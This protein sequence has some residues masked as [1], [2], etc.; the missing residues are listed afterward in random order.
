MSNPTSETTDSL[1]ERLGAADGIA[2]LVDDIVAAH[3]SNPI[4]K[5]RFLPYQEDPARLSAIKSH[6]R[7]FLAMG[8]GGPASYAGRSM[9]DAHRGMNVSAA[10]Y[11]AAVD[12]ILATLK[13]HGRDERTQ[14][15][16]LAI[17]YSLKAE[18]MSL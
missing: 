1:Y 7:A 18:I 10:E 12:D 9:S 17:A 13:K 8:S 5:A 4:I 16:V 3:M 14:Q 2:A 15:E 6:T 11:M